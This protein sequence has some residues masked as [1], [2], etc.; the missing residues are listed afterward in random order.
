MPACWNCGVEVGTPPPE[1]PRGTWIRDKYGA[2]SVRIIDS[3]K[4]DGW[5][6]AEHGFYATGRWDAMWRAR[7]PLE[8]VN[9]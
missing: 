5:A 1:P 7:G 6:P 2:L 4:R 9:D 3:D 8:I